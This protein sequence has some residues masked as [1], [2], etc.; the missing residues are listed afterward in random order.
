MQ[1]R[2]LQIQFH[3]PAFLGDANQSGRWRTPPFKAQ[4]RQWWRV[5]YAVQQQFAVNVREMREVEGRLFGHAWLESDKDDQDNK[6]AAR[7]SQ[8]RIRL[9]QWSEGNESPWSSQ[10][11]QV[12][13]PNVHDRDG[14][15]KP[16]GA[17]LYMGFGPLIFERGTALKANAAIQAKE[18]A[19]L[20]IA[21]PDDQAPLLDHAL[22][23][24]DDYGT[25]GGRSRNG[26]GSYSLHRTDGQAIAVNATPSQLLAKCLREDWPHA[27]GADSQG[28]LA[29]QTMPHKDWAGLM[30]TLAQTKIA[31][32]TQFDFN[33]GKNASVP[34]DRHWLSY[35]VT[36]HSVASWGNNARLPNQLRFK[37]R[38]TVEGQLVGVIFHIPHQPPKEFG[39]NIQ[40]LERIWRQVH[41]H[42]DQTATLKRLT[43]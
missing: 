21:F 2:Q 4:L 39:S 26:W 13:H 17:Q 23:L 31:M 38:P 9:S 28:L 24:M 20:A 33:S 36:N 30:K 25:A 32:R 7:R 34:E 3:T 5:A 22:Q 16:V 19:E 43:A 12:Q 14:R 41:S 27:L 6:V 1:T 42:L 29:W 35:P 40:T 18:E 8:V 10:D 11:A 37:V 15:Q